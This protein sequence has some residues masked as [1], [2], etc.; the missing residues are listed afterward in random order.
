MNEQEARQFVEL[1]TILMNEI[2][3][4]TKTQASD[5]TR[6]LIERFNISTKPSTED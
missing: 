1:R 4:L 2:P 6:L 5:V 3:S